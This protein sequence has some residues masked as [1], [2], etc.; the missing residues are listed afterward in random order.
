[1]MQPVRKRSRRQRFSHVWMLAMPLV[2]IAFLGTQMALQQVER[3]SATYRE[4]P[5][6]SRVAVLQDLPPNTSVMLRGRIAAPAVSDGLIVYQER[7]AE[8][9]EVRFR[10]VFE[11][12]FPAIELALSDGRVR[13]IPRP[14]SDYIIRHAHHTVTIGDRQ[15]SGFR[16]GDVV[17]VQGLWQP[18]RLPV[19]T[20]ATGMTGIDK[21]S[22]LAEWQRAIRNVT[23]VS[24]LTGVL[25]ILGL[26]IIILRV[27]Q[28]RTSHRME[29]NK[30]WRTTKAVPA[31]ETSLSSW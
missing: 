18:E 13:V 7:P 17:T 8:G 10:E 3:K 5:E 11:A 1:M 16:P 14:E 21:A 31:T 25:S 6:I 27:W 20:E 22:L 23:W 19:L 2:W 30:T 26:G 28:W 15:R 24:R 12:H 29:E 4:M 9:R